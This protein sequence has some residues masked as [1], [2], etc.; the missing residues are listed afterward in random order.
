MLN[1]FIEKSMIIPNNLQQHFVVFIHT[2]YIYLIDNMSD[3]M[4]KISNAFELFSLQCTC[5][6]INE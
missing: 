4:F 1:P 3:S 5:F 2:V 6:F